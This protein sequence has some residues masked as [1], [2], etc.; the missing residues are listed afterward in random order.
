[1]RK[2][3]VGKVRREQII[4]AAAAIVAEQGLNKLSLAAARARPE[5][6]R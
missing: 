3:Q 1:M 2:R 5:Q 4:D 6:P